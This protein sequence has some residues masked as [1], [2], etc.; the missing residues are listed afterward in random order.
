MYDIINLDKKIEEN[1]IFFGTRSKYFRIDRVSHSIAKSLKE[2]SEGNTWFTREIDMKLDKTRFISLPENVKR[3]FKLNIAYQTLMDSGVTTGISEVF[4]KNFSSPIW[5]CLYRRISMEENI[6]SESYSYGLSEVFGSE[7]G[8]ILDL[9]YD[10]PMVKKRLDIERNLFGNLEDL[11]NSDIVNKVNDNET[12]MDPYKTNLLKTILGLLCL[13]FIK[14]PFSFLITFIINDKYNNS[15]PGFTRTIQLIAHDEL[16][17]HVPTGIYLLE[18]LKKEEYQD[19]FHLFDENFY[20]FIENL[21]TRTVDSEIEWANYL[22]NNDEFAISVN[23]CEYFIKHRA[24]LLGEILK[25]KISFNK[26]IYESF[27]ERNFLTEF[28]EN[29]RSINKSNSA[30]QETD[31]TS[32]QKGIIKNDL[33]NINPKDYE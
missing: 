33:Y 19:F 28:F 23:S 11:A 25:N 2:K 10:D 26:N 4:L 21:I 30:L 18:I 31:N 22:I 5:E 16:N 3:I 14:F 32:Y 27:K 1:K 24:F 8:E 9:V 15:I 20:N 13:E 29:Y 7:A 12:L 17:I 6:H